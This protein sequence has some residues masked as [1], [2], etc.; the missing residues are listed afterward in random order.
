M[1][2]RLGTGSVRTLVGPPS[3]ASI[4]SIFGMP[5]LLPWAVLALVLTLSRRSRSLRR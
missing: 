4:S 2:G 5:V 3:F 1:T